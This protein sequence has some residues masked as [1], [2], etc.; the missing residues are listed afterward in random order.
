MDKQL[1]ARATVICHRGDRIL[2]VRK[3]EAKWNLPG[4]KIET[5]EGPGDA[6]LRELGEETGLIADVIEFLALHRFEKRAHHVFRMAVHESL[7]ARPQNEI[8]ACGW[9]SPEDFHRLAMKRPCLE[10]LRLYCSPPARA[11]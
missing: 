3:P 10:L 9:F 5:D 8:A 6:A 2:L 4:G 1:K 11:S 7:A